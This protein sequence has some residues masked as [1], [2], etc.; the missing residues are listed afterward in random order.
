MILHLVGKDLLL[1]LIA[2]LEELLYN[3]IPEDVG[4]Q[5]NRVRMY[6][7]ENLF[8]LIAVCRLEFELDE[9]GTVLITTE[10]DNMIVY[11][12]SWVRSQTDWISGASYL[13][14]IS[15]IGLA[16]AS[17]IFEKST[18]PTNSEVLILGWTSGDR[19]VIQEIRHRW[20]WIVGRKRIHS[21]GIL[22]MEVVGVGIWC[23]ELEWIV[24]IREINLLFLLQ[25][26]KLPL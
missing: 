23:S 25:T 16:V 14:L 21:K 18:S 10:L 2:M 3:I 19:R 15:F 11:V 12:L 24:L 8:F 20:Y 17:E 13:K 22:R 7:P 26:S 4:H 1:R 5:L 6:L 9:P